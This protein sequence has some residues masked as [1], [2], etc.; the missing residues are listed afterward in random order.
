M[1]F[2]Q[3]FKTQFAWKICWCISLTYYKARVFYFS[4]SVK[5][6]LADHCSINQFRCLECTL[7][8]AVFRSVWKWPMSIFHTNFLVF[9][10]W[11]FILV[12]NGSWIVWNLIR[13]LTYRNSI[14]T[15]CLDDS[16]ILLYLNSQ[17]YKTRQKVW[18]L[19]T[20]Y[21]LY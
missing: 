4:Y 21:E 12:T 18:C 10:L 2:I 14:H 7:L 3:A 1:K 5:S 15:L 17:V 16:K 13:D 19:C 6:H 9:K 11:N 8:Q 20:P